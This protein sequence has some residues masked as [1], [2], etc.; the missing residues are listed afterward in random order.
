MAFMGTG[1]ASGDNRAVDAAQKAIS[2]PLLVDTSI[3]GAQGVLINIT[4][5]KDI[6]LHEVSKASEL[7]HSL[8]HPEANI[9]F[10][11]VIDE[12]MK[13]MVKVTVIAT[14]FE[15]SAREVMGSEEYASSHSETPPPFEVQKETPPYVFEP[16]GSEVLWNKPAWEKRWE[17]YETPSFIR[18]NKHTPLRKNTHEIS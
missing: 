17:P 7:I 12:N 2:S 5:G 9:I 13:E 15:T 8:A 10:G 3:E 4:G 1:I 11:T 18:K 16:K 14:G 6:T